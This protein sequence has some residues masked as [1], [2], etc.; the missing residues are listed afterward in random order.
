MTGA[1]PMSR[2]I[3]DAITAWA[4]GKP[5]WQ[6]VPP[7]DEIGDWLDFV[8]SPGTVLAA[9]RALVERGVL[10]KDGARFCIAGQVTGESG[11]TS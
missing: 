8:P 4:R 1:T 7:D 10:V 9:K 3:A 5:R 11:A 6:P 2:Q